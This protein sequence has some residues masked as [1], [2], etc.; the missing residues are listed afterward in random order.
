MPAGTFRLPQLTHRACFTPRLERGRHTLAKVCLQ[1]RG[2]SIRTT[3]TCHGLAASARSP[4]SGR[5]SLATLSLQ[6]SGC[7]AS[8]LKSSASWR[9][10]YIRNRQ[11]SRIRRELAVVPRTKPPAFSK[12]PQADGWLTSGTASEHKSSASWR[13]KAALTC[14]D[15]RASERWRE[16]RTRTKASVLNVR[17]CFARVYI[18]LPQYRCRRDGGINQHMKRINAIAALQDLLLL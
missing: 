12:T 3:L 2:T 14:H 7:T 17:D 16:R 8:V 10:A 11:P 1:V 15:F 6:V 5:R 9:L 18:L 4:L 13:L